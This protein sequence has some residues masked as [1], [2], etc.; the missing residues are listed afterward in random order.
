MIARLIGRAICYFRGHKFPY[1]PATLHIAH[2]RRCGISVQ[3]HVMICWMK[4]R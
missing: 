3:R 1:D 2:C 4:A